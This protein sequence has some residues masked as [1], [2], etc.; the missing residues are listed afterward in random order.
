MELSLLAPSFA[1]DRIMEMTLFEKQILADLLDKKLK[2]EAKNP[3][4]KL[5]R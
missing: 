5:F 2:I 3:L 1:Y 4:M